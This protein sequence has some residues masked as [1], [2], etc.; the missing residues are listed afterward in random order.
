MSPENGRKPK[1]KCGQIFMFYSIEHP[2]IH[3][4]NHLSYFSAH[5]V[6]SIPL[7]SPV[8]FAY[9]A[10]FGPVYAVD[11]SPYHRNLFISCGGD[12]TVRVYSMLQVG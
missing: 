9:N 1:L 12:N 11:S 8:T 5:V 6:S 10:H 7:R 4:E 2:F 3:H